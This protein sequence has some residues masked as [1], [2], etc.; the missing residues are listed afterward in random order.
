MNNRSQSHDSITLLSE[1]QS[2]DSQFEELSLSSGGLKW[3]VSLGYRRWKDF[4]LGNQ[5]GQD[6]AVVRGGV[7]H[8]VG[9]VADGVSQSF[10]GNIASKSLS[11]A[12]V[13]ML[14]GNRVQPLSETSL[15]ERLGELAKKVNDEVEEFNIPP[16]LGRIHQD[17][18]ENMRRQG[19]Q[20]VFAAFVL[21]LGKGDLTLYQVSD[22][23]ALVHYFNGSGEQIRAPKTG[24][25][26]TAATGRL[27][28][29][30]SRRSDVSGIVIKSD[31]IGEDWGRTLGEAVINKTSFE[32]LA[33]DFAGSDDVSFI[34]IRIDGKHYPEIYSGGSLAI[35]AR[36][37]AADPIP[38]PSIEEIPA[39]QLIPT[40][41][42]RR[43]TL[44][45]G[46]GL[47][48][49]VVVAIISMSFY[50]WRQGKLN[51]VESKAR[52]EAE[53]SAVPTPPS[54]VEKE[55]SKEEG[56]HNALKAE[57]QNHNDGAKTSQQRSGR[58]RRMSRSSGAALA[59]KEAPSA[60][61]KS[62][63]PKTAGQ[64][65]TGTAPSANKRN[66]NTN[67]KAI[68]P[69]NLGQTNNPPRKLDTK[70]VTPGSDSVNKANLNNNRRI[71]P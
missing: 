15:K 48:A 69:S 61:K 1:Q 55:E 13:E 34:A 33:N 71:K 2:S 62:D 32:Q 26:S 12:L 68:S 19:S 29:R 60:K 20:A 16:S 47:V 49:G 9:V 43:D 17:A 8:V 65:G 27:H 5:P 59:K 11:T 53:V 24:R 57:S 6:F 39:E 50:S 67:Q 37:T 44:L 42:S 64:S 63:S 22:V 14:W 66:D 54:R 4:D 10:Y 38:A 51:R 46:V 56:T 52:T 28:L 31:G 25:W 45:V 58:H 21:N 30:M 3:V 70:S 35:A 7:D 36:N 23:N 18:L 40:R 41:H